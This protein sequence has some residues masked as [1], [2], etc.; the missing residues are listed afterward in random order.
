MYSDCSPV[1]DCLQIDSEAKGERKK[2]S[3]EVQSIL[4]E[5][6]AWKSFAPMNRSRHSG[7]ND[8][9]QD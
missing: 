6:S 3:K 5:I 1:R 7:I 2:N 8:F 4:T 9:A